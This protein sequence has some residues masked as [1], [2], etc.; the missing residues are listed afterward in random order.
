MRNG[1]QHKS[2]AAFETAQ[3]SAYMG[4]SRIAPINLCNGI[5]KT[6]TSVCCKLT[7]LTT[8]LLQ[9]CFISQEKRVFYL[10]ICSSCKELVKSGIG[11]SNSQLV[12]HMAHKPIAILAVF[13][14]HVMFLFGIF[15][16]NI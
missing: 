1:V 13:G 2:I 15:N 7:F 4:H 6:N 3:K 5:F 9:A 11:N 16:A 10:K 12:Q 8:A 14:N